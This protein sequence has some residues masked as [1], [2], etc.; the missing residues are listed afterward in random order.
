MGQDAPNG[1]YTLIV[2]FMNGYKRKVISRVEPVVLLRATPPEEHFYDLVPRLL[3]ENGRDL[4]K[5]L[6][7]LVREYGFKVPGQQA[8]ILNVKEPI[9]LGEG[10]RKGSNQRRPYRH[11]SPPLR[12]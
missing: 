4:Q 5:T 11:R 2:Y 1:V 6:E 8:M 3:K 10:Y 7:L 9:D 12:T